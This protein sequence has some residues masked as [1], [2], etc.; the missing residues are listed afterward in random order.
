ML[1]MYFAL[2]VPDLKVDQDI[3]NIGL[4]FMGLLVVMGIGILAWHSV[5]ILINR[6]R[7]KRTEKAKVE[8][9]IW[10]DTYKSILHKGSKQVSIP[11][12]SLEYYVCKRVFNNPKVYQDDWDVL[13][14]AN[15]RDKKDRAVYFAVDR[16]NSK[17]KK[18]FK[19]ESKLLK[20]SEQKTR[21]N[22]N[23]F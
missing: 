18:A 2:N 12:S 10:F 19:L 11:E 5:P 21:L 22:D 3:T 17:A 6:S 16:I 23:Y 7:T 1:I 4:F 14:D 15:E 20:R 9:Q 8:G 13:N